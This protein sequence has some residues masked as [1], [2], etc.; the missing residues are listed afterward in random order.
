MEYKISELAGICNVNKETIR[1]Y[2]RK[3]LIPKPY[4]NNSGYRI[5]GD[6]TVKRVSFIKKMQDLGFSLSEIYKLLGIVDKDS[7]RCQ[8][9][10]QFVS[11][12]QM[13]VEKKINDLKHIQKV[14][15][16]L[17]DCCPNERDLYACPIIE[18]VLDDSG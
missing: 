18:N 3:S 17:K 9:M 13:D 2:E 15:S 14:L 6:S 4:R 8:D 7:D 5:Y 1:Y 11:E 16:N 12:K 10:Y